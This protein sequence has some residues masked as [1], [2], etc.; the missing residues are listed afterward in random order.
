MNYKPLPTEFT[1]KGFIFKQIRREGDIA[2][3]KRWKEK[4]NEKCAHF[5]VF[6]IQKYQEREM[7]GIKIEAKEAVPTNELWGKKGFTYLDLGSAEKKFEELK[8][9]F[10][11]EK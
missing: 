5:E 8:R 4:H 1:S 7:C 2:I 11:K 9:E 3:Y 10:T 6:E